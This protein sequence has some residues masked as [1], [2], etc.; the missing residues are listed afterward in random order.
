MKKRPYFEDSPISITAVLII[1]VAVMLFLII[2][3]FPHKIETYAGTPGQLRGAIRHCNT[4][5][6]GTARF[7]GDKEAGWLVVCTYRD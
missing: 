7:S 3:S 5:L 2:D 4:E 1:V 6:N